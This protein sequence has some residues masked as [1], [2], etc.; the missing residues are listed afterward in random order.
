MAWDGLGLSVPADWEPAR[1]GL[2]YM[3]LENPA[4]PKL[5]LRWQ[6]LKK[7]LGPEKVLKRLARQKILKPSGKPQGAVAA[8][9]S[10]LPA[11]CS[12]IACADAT[13]RGADAVLFVLPGESLAVLAAPHA[14]PDE[15]A[16]PWTAS[17]ASLGATSPGAFRLFDVCGEAPEGFRLAAFSVQL[18]H[19]HFQYAFRGESL[20]YYRFA[21]SEVI[22]RGKSFDSWAGGVFSQT[23]VKARRFE[24]GYFEGNPS[25]RYAD[26]NPEGLAGVVRSLTARIFAG[27][28]FARAMAWRPDG[29]KIL[30]AVARHKGGLSP[31]NFEEVC[32]RYVVQAS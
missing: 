7:A 10:A 12:A 31:E 5:T 18:G 20:D 29:S 32:R 1:L 27:A 28:R 26:R 21:P 22:L 16:S 14:L 8:M 3:M 9:L 4:G 25:V 30:A 17:V 11:Q 23:L 6:R 24:P 13:G 2:G 19:F 15:K